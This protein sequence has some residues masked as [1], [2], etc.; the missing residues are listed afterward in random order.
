MSNESVWASSPL[1]VESMTQ[2]EDKNIYNILATREGATAVFTG[3]ERAGKLYKWSKDGIA[4]LG[5]TGVGGRIAKNHKA[6]F[7]DDDEERDVFKIISPGV[8]D[9]DKVYITARVTDDIAEVIEE[10]RASGEDRELIYDVSVECDITKI[11]D[12]ELTLDGGTITGISFTMGN[13]RSKCSIA[14][15][16]GVVAS[17]LDKIPSNIIEDMDMTDNET[18]YKAK[19][20][21]LLAE[22]ETLR[23]ERDA[24]VVASEEVATLQSEKDSVV[25]SFEEYRAKTAPIVE[26]HRAGKL[27]ELTA[28]IGEEA[29]KAYA[30]EEVTICDI[31]KALSVVASM[32]AKLA[33]E[34]ITDS[35]APV[36][37]SAPVTDEELGKTKSLLDIHANFERDTGKTT[38]RKR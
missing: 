7:Q 33:D 15:G 31:D 4:S 14:D 36:Q 17:D 38:I 9:D 35:G 29:A 28:A 34:P 2:G 13:H 1:V 25:A 27:A 22:V 32:K 16:C 3:G 20:E 10:A 5:G 21:S 37:A 24:H 12:E 19:Y 30:S 6:V 8:V 11:N 26:A 23:S 18:D